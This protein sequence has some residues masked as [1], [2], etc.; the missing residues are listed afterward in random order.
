MHGRWNAC[1]EN[2]TSLFV[3]FVTVVTRVFVSGFVQA[4]DVSCLA[5]TKAF[6]EGRINDSQIGC[7]PPSIQLRPIYIMDI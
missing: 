7:K 6:V 1:K 2:G 4:F 5:S 3:S